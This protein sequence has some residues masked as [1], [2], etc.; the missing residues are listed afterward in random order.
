MVSP[1]FFSEKNLITI[2]FCLQINIYKYC[3]IESDRET[4]E[5]KMQIGKKLCVCLIT[6]V[7]TQ[8]VKAQ[9]LE[10]PET[11]IIAIFSADSYNI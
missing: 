10:L 1:I 4:T 8:K 5:V 2:R 9:R 3:I 6:D 7:E 11:V